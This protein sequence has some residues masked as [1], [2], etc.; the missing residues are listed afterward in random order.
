M[1]NIILFFSRQWIGGG[2]AFEHHG[3]FQ[4]VHQPVAIDCEQLS[5]AEKRRVHGADGAADETNRLLSL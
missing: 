5:I 4:C 3:C 1:S 2:V